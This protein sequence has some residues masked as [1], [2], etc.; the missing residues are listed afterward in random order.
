MK[1]FSRLL[2]IFCTSLF[3]TANL[4]AQ[5][6]FINPGF[7]EW[8]EIG[9][10]PNILEPVEWSS[11]K[12]TDDS[13]LNNAA[14]VVWEKSDD[15]HTGNHSIHLFTLSIFGLKV[16]GTITNG[17]IHSSMNPD[18][19]Y[20]YTDPDNAEWHTHLLA[21]PDSLV[22]WYKAKPEPGDYAK[23]KIVMHDGFIAVS[24]NQDTSAYIG[25]GTMFLSGEPVN[26]W[27]R[28]SVPINYYK[29]EK[30]EFTLITISSSKGTEATPGTELWV[31]DL[32]L[33]YN[34]GTGITE[35]KPDNLTLFS[36]DNKLNVLVT[37][38]KNEKFILRV[39]DISGKLHL[40][41]TGKVNQK[42]SYFY[43]LPTGIYV[44]SVSYNGK[45]LTKKINL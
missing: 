38:E 27:K 11:I 32:K 12:S 37:G 21:K 5:Y 35:K 23:V 22:G 33:I 10:G 4:T 42:S 16:P 40:Q 7:E 45:V 8:E 2:L 26:E 13:D 18:S 39:Y 29:T 30:P 44:V 25:S 3:W 24:E 20:T 14:P 43:N 15:A 17:R 36:A 9:F 28:F 41:N 6:Q 34:N 1:Y 31:D 19:G